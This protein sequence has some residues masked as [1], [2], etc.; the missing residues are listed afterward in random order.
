MTES[1]LHDADYDVHNDPYRKTPAEKSR[2][3]CLTAWLTA[4]I[5][6][7]VAAGVMYFAAGP[8]IANEAGLPDWGLFVVGLFAV[9]NIFF[10]AAI[11]A[12]KK[13]GFFGFAASSVIVVAINV[14][15]GV[16][17]LQSVS[18][19]IGVGVLYAVL[20]M[21]DPESGWEQLE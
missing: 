18:L 4:M 6:A 16:G 2:H 12:W 8:A 11:F 20:Q 13:W 3:G 9:L 15:I 21:E 10:I 7:N 1:E 5:L 19:L 14:S 17:V